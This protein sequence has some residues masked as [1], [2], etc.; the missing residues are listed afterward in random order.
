MAAICD[1]HWRH[2]GSIGMKELMIAVE[3]VVRPIQANPRRK[4][5]M[6]QELL[7]HLTSA[8]EEGLTRLG[9]EGAAVEEA[10]RRFGNPKDL[11][12]DL[13]A[14]VPFYERVLF[15]PV[16]GTKWTAAIDRYME[17]KPCESP[18]RR[19]ARWAWLWVMTCFGLLAGP[20]LVIYQ[21]RYDAASLVMAAEWFAGTGGMIGVFLVCA[22]ATYLALSGPLRST[23]ILRATVFAGL[24][25]GIPAVG[26]AALVHG[27][28]DLPIQYGAIAAMTVIGFFMILG[29]SFAARFHEA[30]QRRKEE[31]TKLEIG[32]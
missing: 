3:R 20:A 12:R 31:W 28:L 8:Y 32:D 2:I 5:K 27:I 11:T 9:N 18:F 26:G 21:S 30:A 23:A 25:L 4:M 1:D 17:G 15:T 6:R 24:A 29:A 19:M 7:T 10:V 14:S 22:Y 16:A 13:Q